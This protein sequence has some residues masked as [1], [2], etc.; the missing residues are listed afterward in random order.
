MAEKDLNYK[1]YIYLFNN[2]YDVVVA[3]DFNTTAPQTIAVEDRVGV[4][5]Y[6]KNTP[7]EAKNFF[8]GL[9]SQTTANASFARI[10]IFSDTN[11]DGS[12]ELSW[13]GSIG[14]ESHDLRFW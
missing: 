1:N 8:E 12:Q 2:P 14:N 11:D 9:T 6:N 5:F 10:N 4:Y 3:Q 13:H 7:N